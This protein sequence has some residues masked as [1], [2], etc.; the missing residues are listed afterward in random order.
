MVSLPLFDLAKTVTILLYL[1]KTVL[2][3]VQLVHFSIGIRL[4][5]VPFIDGRVPSSEILFAV[6][7]FMLESPGAVAVH[8]KS[9]IGKNINLTTLY[10]LFLGRTGTIICAYL[11]KEY[12]FT[13]QQAIAFCRLQRPGSVNGAQHVYLLELVVFAD[14]TN[15]NRKEQ[16]LLDLPAIEPLK[17]LPPY[18]K[19][20]LCQE[21]LD[22]AIKVN[23]FSVGK[24]LIP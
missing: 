15:E 8:C 12:K 4:L 17:D 19:V 11:M 21:N 18:S 7:N 13:A 6:L 10:S 2:L 5:D 14:L 24:S 3:F 20:T 9:G 16:W 22:S 23:R 1:R